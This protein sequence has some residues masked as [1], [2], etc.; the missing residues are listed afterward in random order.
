VLD[1]ASTHKAEAIC[2]WL[3]KRPRD[4]AHFT[5]TSASRLNLVESWFSVPERREFA[6]GVYRNTYSLE[7]ALRRYVAAANAGARPFVYTTTADEILAA[8]TRF[9][10]RTSNSPHSA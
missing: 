1:G 3:L 6:R 9:S 4:H 2:R 10:A 7:Q 5:P 8:V